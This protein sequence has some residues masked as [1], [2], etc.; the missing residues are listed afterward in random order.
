VALSAAF[1]ASRL[2]APEARSELAARVAS[3]GVPADLA[4]RAVDELHSLGLIWG[5]DDALRPVHALA[6]LIPQEP[7]LTWPPAPWPPAGREHGPVEAQ[8]GLA[9]LMAVDAVRE[10]V[11]WVDR[12]RPAALRSGGISARD[13]ATASGA[14]GFSPAMCALWL[15]SAAAAR[16]IAV[17]E[18]WLP[19]SRYDRWAALDT[20]RAWAVLA[21]AW[22]DCPR[23]ANEGSTMS[24][25]GDDGL[26]PQIRRFALEI[27]AEA[28][29]GATALEVA[30][31]FEFRRPRGATAARTEAI[32]ASLVEAALLGVVACDTLSPA[33]RAL[34]EH[35]SADAAAAALAPS[36]PPTVDRI[37][38]QADLTV[39]APGPLSPADT[40][41]MIRLAEVESRG[42]A[43]VFRIT[44]EG[45][46]RAL[47]SGLTAE[48]I[49]EFLAERS[50]SPLPQPLGY[51]VQ[52]AAR[53]TAAPSARLRAPAPPA[54]V[55]F[56][57][58]DDFMVDATVRSLQADGDAQQGD[59]SAVQLGPTRGVV[60]GLRKAIASR[61]PVWI[62]YAESDGSCRT[63]LV[64]PIRLADG[65]LT[66]FDHGSERVRTFAVSRITGLAETTAEGAV[67]AD[68]R[69]D[70][71]DDVTEYGAVG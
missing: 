16:L 41:M 36:L 52:D 19:T 46:R 44:S 68:S 42:H 12:Q 65:G 38:V 2:H 20:D 43:T 71:A 23:T 13:V 57:R 7:A 11:A 50:A 64:D 10:V 48:E 55:E 24:P 1:E 4:D 34:L 61:K 8:S 51:L 9:S 17:Q 27:L 67:P 33:G 40:A 6:P 29:D 66:A 45:L 32:K 15:E 58:A 3:R 63:Q 35:R 14:L 70:W 21:R 54:P 60:P 28:Q 30:A 37:F 59:A 39:T 18:S 25:Q 69:L 53:G 49:M 31:E 56:E 47:A 5:P 62:G 26:I 22:L